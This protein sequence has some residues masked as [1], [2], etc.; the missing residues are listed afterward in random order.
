MNEGLQK[1]IRMYRNKSGLA[2]ALGVTPMAITQWGNRGLTMSGAR[3]IYDLTNGKVK[4]KELLPEL[5]EK[6]NPGLYRSK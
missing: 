1:A 2:R 4:L 3:S 5:F 6:P